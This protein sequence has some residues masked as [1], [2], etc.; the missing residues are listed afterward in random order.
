MKERMFFMERELGD[1][2]RRMLFLERH[3]QAVENVNEEVVEDSSENENGSDGGGLDVRMTGCDDNA[4]VFEFVAANEAVENR[5][6][7]DFALNAELSDGLMKSEGTEDACMKEIEPEALTLKDDEKKSERSHY[8]MK[9]EAVDGN[10]PL[11]QIVGEKADEIKGKEISGS[12]F[13][14]DEMVAEEDEDKSRF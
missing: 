9:V 10:N 7:V 1:L 5:R 14:K 4:G 6:N 2:Q 12:D 3:T 13:A 11:G 8:G